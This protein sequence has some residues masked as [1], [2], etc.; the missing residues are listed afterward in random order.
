M[1]SLVCDSCYTLNTYYAH[2]NNNACI[3][4]ITLLLADSDTIK[5]YVIDCGS[6]IKPTFQNM[7]ITVEIQPI[8]TVI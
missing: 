5:E 4:I 8:L 7:K 3:L 6:T 2:L 1:F